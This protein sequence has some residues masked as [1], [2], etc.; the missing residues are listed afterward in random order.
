MPAAWSSLHR[1]LGEAPGR[2]S[3]TH[4][5]RETLGEYERNVQVNALSVDQ[6]FALYERVGFLYPAKAARLKPHL[7]AVR[8][9]WERLLSAGGPLMYAL[10]AGDERE[11]YASVA[12][13]RTTRSSWIWQ[14]L[15][16]EGHPLRSRDVMLGGME[17]G[18]RLGLGESQQNWFRPE[19]RY[20]AR[21]FGSMVQ[22]LGESTASVRRHR[23]FT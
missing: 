21:M 9:N 1:A 13:W 4:I 14:H 7:D 11:G 8:D 10:S 22:A 12:I 19:N 3:R 17:R 5:E 16:C 23:Y 6:L 18:L 15:V 2:V 20:P